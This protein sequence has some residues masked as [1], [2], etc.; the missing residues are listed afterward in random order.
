MGRR[1]PSPGPGELYQRPGAAHPAGPPESVSRE[2]QPALQSCTLQ[3]AQQPAPAQPRGGLCPHHPR[4]SGPHGA[5]QGPAVSVGS[6]KGAAAH[7]PA[8][9]A[10]LIG[11]GPPKQ[12]ALHSVS[13]ADAA[14]RCSNPSSPGPAAASCAAQERHAISASTPAPQ[15]PKRGTVLCPNSQHVVPL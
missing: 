9:E 10:L 11:W 6:F 1:R 3:R 7:L 14:A 8:Q 13:A 4:T 2:T 12:Q 15:V 5:H